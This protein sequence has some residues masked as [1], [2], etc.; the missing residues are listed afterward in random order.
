MIQ[1]RG[2]YLRQGVREASLKRGHLSKDQ[3]EGKELTMRGKSV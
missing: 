3:K 1:T 2:I